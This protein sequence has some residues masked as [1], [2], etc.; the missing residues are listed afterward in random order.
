MLETKFPTP[1]TAVRLNRR[2]LVVMQE[3]SFGVFDMSNLKLMLTV[4]TP[5]NK[6][7]IYYY[8]YY[9]LLFIILFF[10]VMISFL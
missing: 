2:R 1:I 3:K 8:Y 4:E 6:Q 10:D 5:S 9:S 7:G